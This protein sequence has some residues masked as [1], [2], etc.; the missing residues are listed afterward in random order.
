VLFSTFLLS[1]ST[2]VWIWLTTRQ[3]RDGLHLTSLGY[4]VLF[5]QLM[6]LIKT[7]FR[8]RG[9]GPEVE[10]GLPLTVPQYESPFLSS[11]NPEM[12]Y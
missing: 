10:D 5:D 9:L 3:H 8:D 6:N 4:S 1:S 12:E 2:A 11:P 7:E